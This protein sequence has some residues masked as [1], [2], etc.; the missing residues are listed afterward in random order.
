MNISPASWISTV[1]RRMIRQLEMLRLN[2]IQKAAT[3]IT[4]KRR[5]IA[6][7]EQDWR[8]GAKLSFWT[9]AGQDRLPQPIS[10]RQVLFNPDDRC[11]NGFK[12]SDCHQYRG[13]CL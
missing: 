11:A 12:N 13:P 5:C 10:G 9:E 6:G 8:G 1:P 7:F 4:Q 3:E 2:R